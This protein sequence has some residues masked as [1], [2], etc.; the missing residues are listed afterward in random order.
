MTRTA[1]SETEIDEVW[2]RWRCGQAVK[3]LARE[4][5]R[6]PSTVRDLLKRCGGVRAAARRRGELRLSLAD[7]EEISP[8]LAAGESLR[9]IAARLRRGGYRQSLGRSPVAVL[10]ID[11]DGGEPGGCQWTDDDGRKW[12][13]PPPAAGWLSLGDPASR[14]VTIRPPDA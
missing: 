5:G 8:G 9:G 10:D 13:G 12:C 14:L 2:R 7:R 1:L 6:H 3:V 11:L 4:M